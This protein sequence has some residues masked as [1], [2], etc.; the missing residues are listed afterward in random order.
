M[1]LPSA[2]RASLLNCAVEPRGDKTKMTNEER[3]MFVLAVLVWLVTVGH[4]V[5]EGDKLRN[6]LAAANAEMARLEE[7]D[8]EQS[9]GDA[10]RDGWMREHQGDL[11]K[12]IETRMEQEKGQ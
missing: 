12:Q 3:L 9:R 4:A 5:T 8:G 1:L 2:P 6:M 10:I 11:M 7:R